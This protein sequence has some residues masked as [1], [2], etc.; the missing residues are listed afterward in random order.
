M[1]ITKPVLAVDFDEAHLDFSTG[2]IA[3]P[4]VDGVR[5]LHFSG[6]TISYK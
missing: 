1:E 2:I 6:R 5:G 3:L 4:K